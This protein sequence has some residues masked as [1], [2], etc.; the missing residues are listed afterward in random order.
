MLKMKIEKLTDFGAERKTLQ[1]SC[2]YSTIRP[3]TI[4]ITLF[5]CSS[6]CFILYKAV[7]DINFFPG[8]QS[9]SFPNFLIVYLINC[10]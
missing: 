10:S 5:N 9:Q 4:K 3:T 2:G 8:Y 7:E 6:R 1:P